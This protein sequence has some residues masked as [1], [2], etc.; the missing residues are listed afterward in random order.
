MNTYD[1]LMSFKNVITKK[2]QLPYLQIHV[3]VYNL[4]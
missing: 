2:I 1:V 4:E 3:K